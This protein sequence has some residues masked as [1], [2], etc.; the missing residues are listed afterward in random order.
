MK[1]YK[2]SKL[3]GF[4]SAAIIGSSLLTLGC[5]K[6]L[7][8]EQCKV[9][10]SKDNYSEA[11]KFCSVAAEQGHPEAQN[12]LG[13]LYFCG[14]GVNKNNKE[15]F[16]WYEKAA[17]QGFVEAQANLGSSYMLGIGVK[18][19][20]Y[21]AKKWFEKAAKQGSSS[22]LR[23]LGNMYYNGYGVRQ[24]YSKAKEYYGLA[25]DNGDQLGCDIYK[26]LNK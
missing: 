23:S 5:S 17:E 16:K 19:N 6:D 9:N 3:A 11:F 26:R 20:F 15:S 13:N 22:S 2:F 25:C 7:E 21:E 1:L 4:F 10:Y 24:D 18:Q 12:I 8:L 14:R